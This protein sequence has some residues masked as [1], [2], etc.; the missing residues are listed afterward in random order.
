MVYAPLKVSAPGNIMLMGEHAVL[1]GYPALVATVDKRLSIQLTSRTDNT[2]VINSASLGSYHGSIDKLE[3]E[4]PFEFVIA[5]LQHWQKHLKV[6]FELEIHS[7]FSHKV[8]LGSSAAVTVAALKLFSEYLQQPMDQHTLLV[9]AHDIIQQIQGRGSGADVAASI[10][11]GIC[12]YHMQTNQVEVIAQQ[13]PITLV[14][15]GNKVPTTE[16]LA[17]LAAKSK[18]NPELYEHLYKYIGQVVTDSVQCIQ[19]QDYNCLGLLMNLHQKLQSLLGVNTSRLQEICDNLIAFD[20]IFGAKISGSGLGDSVIGLG[21]IPAGS[22]PQ[23][24]KQQAQGVREIPMAVCAEGVRV[25]S[26]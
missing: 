17:L 20:S 7:E 9:T 10:Y 12:L 5:A 18:Q 11:G 6:G 26:L 2:I 19:H 15:S 4:Q 14:Y 21:E 16:V 24:E 23:T 25:E 13:L 3:L 22:F 1:Q 8:G